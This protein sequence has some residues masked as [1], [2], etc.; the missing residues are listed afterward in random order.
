MWE[1]VW[2]GTASRGLNS[3]YWAWSGDGEGNN[4]SSN[5][6]YNSLTAIGKYLVNDSSAALKKNSVKSSY[7]LNAHV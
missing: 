1:Q 5:G 6:S 2:E 7:L 4:M 3:F